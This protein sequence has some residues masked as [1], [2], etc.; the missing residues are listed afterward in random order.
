[1]L[2]LES[3][4]ITGLFKLALALLGII[5]CRVALFWFDCFFKDTH[6]TAWQENIDV[7][8]KA[9]YNGL[10]HSGRFIA[11]AIIVGCAIG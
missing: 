4:L 2:G 3:V 7:K 11:I 9:L 6:F 1:M 8:S 10:Y 5:M